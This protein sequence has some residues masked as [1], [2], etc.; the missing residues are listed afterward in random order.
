MLPSM[1][2]FF[3]LLLQEAKD[4]LSEWLDKKWGSS[5]TNNSIFAELPRYWEEEFHKDMARLNVS[6][7]GVIFQIL[8]FFSTFSLALFH[9]FSL[10]TL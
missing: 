7:L 8:L 4:P 3:Q 2:S 10:P 9:R 5:I 1:F 6:S